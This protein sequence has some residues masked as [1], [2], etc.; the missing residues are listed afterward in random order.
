[1]PS[2]HVTGAASDRGRCMVQKKRSCS[3][4]SARANASP[5][6]LGSQWLILSRPLP[7]RK[8]ISRIAA[9]ASARPRPRRRSGSRTPTR[10]SVQSPLREVKSTSDAKPARPVAALVTHTPRGV[11]NGWRRGS[12]SSPLASSQPNSAASDGWCNSVRNARGVVGAVDTHGR[13]R[14]RPVLGSGGARVR[15][16]T[17]A[18]RRTRSRSPTRTR[19]RYT[20]GDTLEASH[21]SGQ[22]PAAYSRTGLDHTSR[23]CTS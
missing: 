19:I 20:P 13:R 7:G 12:F 3:N 16:R 21:R 1:M 5:A 14:R 17:T 11:P 15:H 8:A 9:V 4:P 22:R 23:P 18:T 2:G 10:S 6:G